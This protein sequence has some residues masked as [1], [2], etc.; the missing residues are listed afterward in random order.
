M[1][2]KRLESVLRAVR[3]PSVPVNAFLADTLIEAIREPGSGVHLIVFD[4]PGSGDSLDRLAD[5][6]QQARPGANV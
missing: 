5:L 4:P 6:K 3:D 1:M 2:K